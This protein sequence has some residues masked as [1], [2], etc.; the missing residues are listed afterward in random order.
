MRYQAILI[1]AQSEKARDQEWVMLVTEF[2]RVYA[3]DLSRE[4][5]GQVTD[6]K[7]Y[8]S[9][10]TEQLRSAASELESGSFDE[11][12][13]KCE[14]MTNSDVPIEDHPALTI[15]IPKPTA[16]PIG[17]VDGYTL[18]VVIRNGLPS[19]GVF[20]LLTVIR[21]IAFV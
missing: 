10:L 3:S 19:V 17:I 13:S 2:L 14:L 18:D 20:E 9:A 6:P 21:M 15:E 16:R 12:H 8:L 1:H 4:L 5:L 11:Y 7:A